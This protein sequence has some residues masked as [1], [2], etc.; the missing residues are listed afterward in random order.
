M[1]AVASTDLS[2]L[3]EA[4]ALVSDGVWTAAA[5]DIEEG[6]EHVG[7]AVL[8]RTHEHNGDYDE[9]EGA[10]NA[11]CDDAA[12][13]R[14]ASPSAILTLIVRAEAAEERRDAAHNA[15]RAAESRELAALAEL[16][17]ARAERDEARR[18]RDALRAEVI[19]SNRAHSRTLGCVLRMLA[20]VESG[21]PPQ[22]DAHGAFDDLDKDGEP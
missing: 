1:S 10:R 13:V 14:L 2:K 9:E 8:T 15:L 7:W 6:E 4:A 21:P 22:F 17:E 20:K 19:A 5:T 12:F 3:V 11:A 18:E 16:D